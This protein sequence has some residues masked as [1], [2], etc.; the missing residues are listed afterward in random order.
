V[1]F[2]WEEVCADGVAT[3]D[4]DPILPDNINEHQQFKYYALDL[5][6]KIAGTL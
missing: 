6:N 3:P 1:S 2:S 4:R 5:I